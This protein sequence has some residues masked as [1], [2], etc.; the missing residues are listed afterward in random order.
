MVVLIRTAAQ[1]S[2]RISFKKHPFGVDF[3]GRPIFM[4][5]IPDSEKHC[6][7]S[8]SPLL[9]LRVR[10]GSQVASNSGMAV[11]AN[12]PPAQAQTAPRQGAGGHASTK[13]PT[14]MT[15]I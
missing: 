6:V 1:F 8:S 10:N 11:P 5:F 13:F 15:M 4:Q 12:P 9:Q 2:G 3:P 7:Q 14:L